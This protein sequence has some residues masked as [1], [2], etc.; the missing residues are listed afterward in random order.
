MARYYKIAK[1]SETGRKVLIVIK[2]LEELKEEV[3]NFCIDYK[4]NQ[5]IGDEYSI[6]SVVDIEDRN[7]KLWRGVDFG[8]RFVPRCRPQ[9]SCSPDEKR[10]LVDLNK[11]WNL[12]RKKYATAE[13]INHEW[14]CSY[15]KWKN[16]ILNH[17]EY[18]LFSIPDTFCDNC[19][20]TSDCVEITNIEYADLIKE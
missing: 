11:R 5:Y 16:A 20:F 18:F 13:F 19:K 15:M 12:L 9:L 6:N 7:D 3:L 10:A 17:K 2:N 8:K 1:E 4:I 14:A